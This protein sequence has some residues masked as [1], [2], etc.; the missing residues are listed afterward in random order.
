MWPTFLEFGGSRHA[1]PSPE[2]KALMLNPPSRTSDRESGAAK[3]SVRRRL[4]LSGV[5]AVTALVGSAPAMA[6]PLAAPVGPSP[7]VNPA[8]ASQQGIIMRDGGIC[9]PI[10]HMGC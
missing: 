7:T 9:D 1:H 2:R 8:G 3:R 5:I 6:T 10:R 4:A